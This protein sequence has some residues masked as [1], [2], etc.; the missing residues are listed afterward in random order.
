MRAESPAATGRVTTQA[1]TMFMKSL[2]LT[3]DLERQRPTVTT[4]PT[5]Q[6][7]VDMGMPRLLAIKTVIADPNSMH[8]PLK[9][10][11]FKISINIQPNSIAQTGYKQ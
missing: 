8:T 3:L 2:Q 7:V 11:L 1:T 5:L 6:C 9:N 10:K 4:E